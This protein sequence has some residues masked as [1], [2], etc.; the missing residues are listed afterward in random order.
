MP[1]TQ[2]EI[3]EHLG[4]SQQ[5]V[6][7]WLAR[8]ALDVDAGLD[9]IRLA[10]IE[11]LRTAAAGGGSN[12]EKDG[13][14]RARRHLAEL[15]LQRERA[16]VC[17]VAAVGAVARETHRDLRNDLLALPDRLAVVLDPASPAR[18]HKLLNAAIRKL[19]DEHVRRLGASA[20]RAGVQLTAEEL[21]RGNE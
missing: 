16:L 7:A 12:P 19:L 17:D 3:A 13:Y 8:L 15:Q 20:M 2:Q 6:S 4:L 21:Q 18:A 9:A 1:L 5:Q 10:Y 11:A 14:V